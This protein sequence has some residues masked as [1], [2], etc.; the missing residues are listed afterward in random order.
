MDN[1]QSIIELFKG[2]EK[3]MALV[4]EQMT[5]NVMAQMNE[6]QLELLA[7]ARKV[8]SK[9]ELK[10]MTTKLSDLSERMQKNNK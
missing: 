8:S 1:S 6:E 7:E 4:N 10:K 2:V 5:T 3:A 9:S